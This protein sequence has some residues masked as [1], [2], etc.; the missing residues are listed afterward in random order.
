MK[1]SASLR[2]PRCL[3]RSVR[4]GEGLTGPEDFE[5]EVRSMDGELRQCRDCGLGGFVEEFEDRCPP[6]CLQ[7]AQERETPCLSRSKTA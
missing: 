2:C 3:S 4:D 6:G 5:V 1:D 7:V